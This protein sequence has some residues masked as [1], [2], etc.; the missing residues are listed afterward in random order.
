MEYWKVGMLEYCEE[1][2]SYSEHERGHRFNANVIRVTEVCGV[3]GVRVFNT[4]TR[5]HKGMKD[6]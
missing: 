3:F 2:E 1:R 5:K 4:E 6:W